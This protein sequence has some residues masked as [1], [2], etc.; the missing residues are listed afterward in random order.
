MTKKR[1][2]LNDMSLAALA[3][4]Q[5]AQEKY[6]IDINETTYEQHKVFI[7]AN[8]PKIHKSHGLQEFDI[9]G[10]KIWAL[11]QRNAE[12]KFNKLNLN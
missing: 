4:S 6:F 9:N 1:Q 10:H 3:M 11:N 8:M 12:R 2:L 7:E 5:T